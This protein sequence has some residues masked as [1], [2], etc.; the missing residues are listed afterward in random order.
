LT[1]DDGFF[2]V[3]IILSF[4]SNVVAGGTISYLIRG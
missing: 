4:R 2:M 3:Y 1:D